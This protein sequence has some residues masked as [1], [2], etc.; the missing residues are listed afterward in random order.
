M[1]RHYFQNTQALVYVIDSND[2]DRIAEAKEE[3]FQV[4]NQ[5]ELKDCPILV[6]ANKQDLQNRMT[7][8][9]IKTNLDIS[10]FEGK[11]INILGTCALKGD[12]LNEA[13]E[14]LSQV[15]L[16]QESANQLLFPFNET[17]QDVKI[18]ANEMRNQSIDNSWSTYLTNLSSKFI[19]LIGF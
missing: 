8:D 5:D 9:E 1:W 17:I 2:R 11:K 7:I 12:G 6:L 19:N 16:G 18:I 3:L 14:W 10:N 4:T 15:I 13:F